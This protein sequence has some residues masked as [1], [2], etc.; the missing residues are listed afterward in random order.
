M[1]WS[2]TGAT[3]YPAQLGLPDKGRAI[4]V[5]CYVVWLGSMKGIG[6]RTYLSCM[7]LVPCW[8]QDSYRAQV[9]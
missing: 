9:P 3:H 6:L 8:G 5:V 4:E 2:Q 7:G 1:P